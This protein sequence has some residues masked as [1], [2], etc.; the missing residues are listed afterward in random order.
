MPY[1]W[2]VVAVLMLAYALSFIDRKI[3]FILAESIKHDLKLNDTELGLLTGMAFTLV[4]ATAAIPIASLADRRSRKWIIAIAVAVW[5]VMT[6]LGGFAANFLQ[7]AA[8]RSGVAIGEAASSPAALSMLA[9]YFPSNYR[10]RAVGLYMAGAQLG[11][12]VG[13]P[14]GG[15]ISDL[16]N[17]RTAMLLVGVPGLAVTLL[18]LLTV[19]EP[20]RATQPLREL[21]SRSTLGNLRQLFASPTYRHL[22]IGGLLFNTASAGVLSFGPA[23]VIRTYHLSA[24]R[25][26]LTYG[27]VIGV[28]GVLGAAVG[29]FAADWLRTR[30]LRYP[31]VAFAAAVVLGVP[32][33]VA[34]LLVHGYWG[35]LFLLAVPQFVGMTYA[36]PSFSTIYAIVPAR[37]RALAAAVFLFALNGI[38]LSAGSL[39]A[40][41]LS[42]GF[43]ALGTAASLRVAL[44]LLSSLNVWAAIHYVIAA[45]K[46]KADLTR[47]EAD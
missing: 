12:L 33:L 3:P 39:M 16:S 45:S 21:S 34:A 14:L 37:N 23:Y 6:S 30:D 31:L 26:G 41:A 17:W 47:V 29:G 25:T 4:Y 32:F 13:L 8:S 15:V 1:A 27:I 43:A 7:L 38:G 22:F 42:D 5:S 44:L 28:A 9:D 2:Y 36:G 19:R 10:A 18:I 46:L 11:I 40:G 20:L 24:S 35:F